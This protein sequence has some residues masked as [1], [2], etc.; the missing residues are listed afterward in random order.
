MIFELFC[1]PLR[2]LINGIIA[3]LPVFNTINDTV[4][5]LLDMLST[6]LQFF[7]TDV[8]I[9]SLGSIVF[10]LSTRLTMSIVFFVLDVIVGVIP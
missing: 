7:P 8:W 2:L 5:G 1:T 9:L 3:L 10:W 4:A 6:A